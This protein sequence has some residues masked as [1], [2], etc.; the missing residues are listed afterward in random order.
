MNSEMSVVYVFD[1][2]RRDNPLENRGCK[3]DRWYDCVINYY[4]K[5]ARQC[6]IGE[7]IRPA[8]P[9]GPAAWR[10]LFLPQ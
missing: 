7:E 6:I 10:A 8:R 4:N 3:G 5:K 1:H 2:T 9:W